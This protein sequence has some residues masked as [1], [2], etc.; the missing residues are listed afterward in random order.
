MG[1]LISIQDKSTINALFDGVLL[2]G[3]VQKFQINGTNVVK[4]T[5]KTAQPTYIAADGSG[6]TK[7]LNAYNRK[8]VQAQYSAFTNPKIAVDF[9]FKYDE[10][11]MTTRQLKGESVRVL[12]LPDIMHII[13]TPKTYYLIEPSIINQLS[14]GDNP[15]YS[16]YGIPV[17]ITSWSMTTDAGTKDVTVSITFDETID[18]FLGV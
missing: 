18:E 14:V 17:V 3:Q 4:T 13:M 10:K 1:D 7:F 11:D 8:K 12:T 6:T 9:T 2:Y 15:Y 16:T 5:N